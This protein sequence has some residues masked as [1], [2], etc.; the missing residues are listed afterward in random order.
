MEGSQVRADLSRIVCRKGGADRK[1]E[2][3]VVLQ[4]TIP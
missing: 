3:L 1:K 4:R 2:R